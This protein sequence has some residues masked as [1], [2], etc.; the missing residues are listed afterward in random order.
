MKFKLASVFAIS[1]V[2]IRVYIYIY[3]DMHSLLYLS[4]NKII[5][6]IEHVK[7]K[8]WLNG[9]YNDFSWDIIE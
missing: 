3:I 4:N 8:I 9:I 2:V 5:T 1:Y 6:Y 7:I